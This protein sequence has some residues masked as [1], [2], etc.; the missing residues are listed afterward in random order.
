MKH[1]K[2][3]FLAFTLL[4]VSMELSSAVWADG[5]H[6]LTVVAKPTMAG[7]FNKSEAELV[8]ELL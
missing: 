1:I 8:A 5:G 4:I 3:T 2:S 7:T 6:R